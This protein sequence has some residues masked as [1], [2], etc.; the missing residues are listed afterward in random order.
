M[1]CA[2]NEYYRYFS[3]FEGT[4]LVIVGWERCDNRGEVTGCSFSGPQDIQ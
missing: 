3:Y 4:H 1:F 2:Q